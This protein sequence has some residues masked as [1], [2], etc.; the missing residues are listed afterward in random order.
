MRLGK[1]GD[2]GRF[3]FE[4]GLEDNDGLVQV[5]DAATSHVPLGLQ[6]AQHVVL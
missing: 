3:I 4:Q 2:F 1:P 6:P 5:P